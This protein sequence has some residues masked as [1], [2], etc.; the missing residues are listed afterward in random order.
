MNRKT[1]QTLLIKTFILAGVIRI[2]SVAGDSLIGI[3]DTVRDSKDISWV[4]LRHKDWA[5]F[6]DRAEAHLV[7]RD[8][9]KFQSYVEYLSLAQEQIL[10]KLLHEIQKRDG[11]TLRLR[12]TPSS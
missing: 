5:A 2:F 12:C 9:N 10:W 8:L 7:Y 1:A 6:A 3:A 4:S 11:R